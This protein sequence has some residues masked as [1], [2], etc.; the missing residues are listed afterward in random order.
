[1]KKAEKP[2]SRDLV[3]GIISGIP[4]LLFIVGPHLPAINSD[5]LLIFA[6]AGAIPGLILGYIAWF[7]LSNYMVEFKRW[8]DQSS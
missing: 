3:T 2:P 5:F 4:A 1:M 7:K 8:K 6:L